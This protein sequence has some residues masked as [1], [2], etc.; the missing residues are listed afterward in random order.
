MS[1]VS[2]PDEYHAPRL[3]I[4]GLL[5]RAVGLV[6]LL[7]VLYVTA[8]LTLAYVAPPIDVP[9]IESDHA[10]SKHGY[11]AIAIRAC[12]AQMGATEVWQ[13]RSWKDLFKFFRVCQLPTGEWGIQIVRFAPRILSWR[14]VTAYIVKD[15]RYHQIRE[16]LSGIAIQ[17]K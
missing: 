3:G 13:S 17:V 8:G 5:L 1:A 11:E 10:V 6:A 4:G 9:V 7:F 15:G 14:E 2:Y 16:Y 12:L